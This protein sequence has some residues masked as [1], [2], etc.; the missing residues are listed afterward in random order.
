MEYL[1]TKMELKR[2]KNSDGLQGRVD[3]HGGEIGTGSV[4]V[5][6]WVVSS[7]VQRGWHG[8]FGWN[9]GGVIICLYM[10]CR[11]YVCMHVVTNVD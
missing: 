10:L 9:G 6:P 11:L 5:D 4:V 2:L 8:E 3:E 7:G 1:N